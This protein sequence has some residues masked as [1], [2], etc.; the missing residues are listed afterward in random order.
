M[1]PDEA[2]GVALLTRAPS[3]EPEGFHTA[4]AH[5]YRGEMQRMTVWRSRLDA[6]S[7]WAILLTTGMT[8]FTLGSTA[9][10]HYIMLLCL[11]LIG[12]CMVI[13]ARRYRHVLHSKWRVHILEANYFGQQICPNEPVPDPGWRKH[14]AEDLRNPTLRTS[15]LMAFRLRLRRN[16]LL[17]VYF[18]SAVWLTKVFLHPIGAKNVYEFHGRLAVGE[19][20][21]SWFVAITA[22]FFVLTCTVLAAM[23][24]SE[25]AMGD[26]PFSPRKSP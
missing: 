8:T 12:I 11:A 25:E 6:T 1:R 13:E 18:I 7:N 26:G 16:Y 5:L 23:S 17:L 22:A 3:G 15:L 2:S 4:M 20:I 14:L 21:A 10:P 19:M 9:I 24:P